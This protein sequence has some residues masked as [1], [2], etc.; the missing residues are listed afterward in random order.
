[1]CVRRIWS[2]T[3][4]QSVTN[5][6]DAASQTRHPLALQINIYRTRLVY[7]LLRLIEHFTPNDWVAF[8][9]VVLKSC[10]II[11]IPQR[12]ILGISTAHK[13]RKETKRIQFPSFAVFIRP[14]FCRTVPG[15]NKSIGCLGLLMAQLTVNPR[16]I[17]KKSTAIFI[18]MGDRK[19]TL[20]KER[21]GN[22]KKK[23]RIHFPWGNRFLLYFYF[24][25]TTL[26]TFYYIICLDFICFYQPDR[27]V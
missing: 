9:F 21:N 27:I 2:H 20:I 22:N 12:L 18:G 4:S 15:S 1:M 16:Q 11:H 8:F 6:F 26:N 23:K 17:K 14:S 10:S 5:V 7:L 25:Q 19:G 24:C 13:K 3:N